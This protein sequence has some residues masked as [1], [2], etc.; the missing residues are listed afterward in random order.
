MGTT[1]GTTIHPSDE[2]PDLPDTIGRYKVL[3]VLGEG[4]F[5]RVFLALDEELERRVAIKVPSPARSEWPPDVEAFLVE[6][7]ILAS[8][9]HPNIVP[10]FDFGRTSLGL[11]YVVSKF[12]EGSDLAG[13]L[14]Q[15]SS[16]YR[17]AAKLV[18]T[19]ADALHYAHARRLVHRDVK[20]RNILIDAQ[21][22]PYLA[23]FGLALRE[24]DFGKG[25]TFAGTIAY[26]SP[27]QA[28][29]EGHLVDGRS[30]I[31]SLSVVFYELLT[32]TC[33]FRGDSQ[34]ETLEQ[35]KTLEARR[36]ASAMIASPVSSSGSA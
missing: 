17:E 6:A 26:M 33:P 29:G 5:G 13:G 16:S 8:L 36:R 3:G 24:E 7:R 14:K 4:G 20:P 22:C 21:G 10:V 12:I 34:H 31:F 28:R 19:V 32:G 18:A 15:G 1:G 25:P 9:D 11:C 30:D 2:A 27:E 35:I 23:D